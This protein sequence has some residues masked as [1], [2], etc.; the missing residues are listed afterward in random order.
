MS[1]AC[2]RVAH[3]FVV[4]VTEVQGSGQNI[5]QIRLKENRAQRFNSDSGSLKDEGEKH[6]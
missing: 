5:K 2:L 1:K 4:N 3:G 6:A